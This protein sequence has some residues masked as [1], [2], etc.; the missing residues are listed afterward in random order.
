M[1]KRNCDKCHEKHEVLMC[2]ECVDKTRIKYVVNGLLTYVQSYID[3]YS[4]ASLKD[5]IVKHFDPKDIAAGRVALQEVCRDII[6]DF[7]E[8]QGA[9]T[10][11]TLREKHEIEAD[12]ICAAM[13]EMKRLLGDEAEEVPTFV[14]DDVRKLP[15]AAPEEHNLL[16]ILERMLKMEQQLQSMSSAVEVNRIELVAQKEDISGQE[17]RLST[18]ENKKSYASH[19]KAGIKV[20]DKKTTDPTSVN[21]KS[22]HQH[23]VVT[24]A[25]AGPST[26][27]GLAQQRVNQGSTNARAEPQANNRREAENSTNRNPWQQQGRRR[28]PVVVGAKMNAGVNRVV[29]GPNEIDIKV[30][31]V[32]PSCEREDIKAAVEA[33]GIVVKDVVMLSKPEWRTRSFKITVTAKDKEKVMSPDMW[34][35]GIKVG[36]FYPERKPRNQQNNGY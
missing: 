21:G 17:T 29:A 26:G 9:R 8:I 22:Q 1:P 11:S 23:K 10:S 27:N 25:V 32:S 7:K 33:E 28:R 31:N 36:F 19:V 3:Q 20:D 4:T 6:P 16:N 5:A 30:W 24:P 14:A 18:L 35:S 2:T 15:K 34:D 12:D 13:L